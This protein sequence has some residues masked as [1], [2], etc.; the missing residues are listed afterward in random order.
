[1]PFF[2][3]YVAFW[4]NWY[5]IL[6]LFRPLICFQPL[7]MPVFLLPFRKNDACYFAVSVLW[8]HSTRLIFTSC[9]IDT[10]FFAFSILFSPISNHPLMNLSP[11]FLV[12]IFKLIPLISPDYPIFPCFSAS[13][14]VLIPFRSPA[15]RQKNFK[16]FYFARNTS[17]LKVFLDMIPD[18]SPF[19][20][21]AKSL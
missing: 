2:K 5:H 15:V 18:C 17:I 4:N 9:P 19:F 16:K 7:N 1:M 21:Q 8:C 3:K 10:L 11:V 6:R 14:P 12:K 13:R 20:L